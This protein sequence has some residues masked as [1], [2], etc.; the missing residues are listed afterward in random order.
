MIEEIEAAF[1]VFTWVHPRSMGGRLAL[2]LVQF[3]DVPSGGLKRS[4]MVQH[5][6]DVL[7]DVCDSAD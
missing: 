6:L 1:V 3:A 7:V 4:A 5:R 2:A